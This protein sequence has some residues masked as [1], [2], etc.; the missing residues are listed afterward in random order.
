[1]LTSAIE[2]LGVSVTFIHLNDPGTY[3]PV[4]TVRY[5]G[6]VAWSTPDIRKLPKEQRNALVEEAVR[7]V[8][9]LHTTK[10]VGV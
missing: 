3:N 10:R 8:T 6:V 9:T 4:V 7:Y 5:R 1:M 2:D